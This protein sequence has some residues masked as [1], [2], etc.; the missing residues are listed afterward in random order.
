MKEVKILKIKD[1]Y[2]DRISTR[3]VNDIQI[4]FNGTFSYTQKEL[5]E[6]FMS[7]YYNH[8]IEETDVTSPEYTIDY[9]DETELIYVTSESIL[10]PIGS[11]L[12]DFN[13]SSDTTVCPDEK[14]SDKQV[15]TRKPRTKK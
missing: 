3:M 7:K 15:K 14:S 5:Q 10:K 12:S 9:N 4:L 6:M 1:K 8:F 2:V 13:E 11:D